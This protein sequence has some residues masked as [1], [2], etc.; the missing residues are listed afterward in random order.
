MFRTG[1]LDALGASVVEKVST[2]RNLKRGYGMHTYDVVIVGA[3][4][5][6]L[7]AAYELRDWD[8][9]VLEKEGRSGG[10]ILTRSRGGVSYD[11]GAV[12]AIDHRI[13]PFEFKTSDLIYEDER[14]GLFMDGRVHYGAGV[15]ECLCCMGIDAQDREAIRKFRVDQERDARLLPEPIYKILNAFFQVIHPGE[16]EEYLPHRRLDALLK[17]VVTHYEG[18]N[19]E[20]IGQFEERLGQRVRLTAEVLSVAEERGRVR[21]K[22][23]H[24]NKRCEVFAKTVILSPPGPVALRVLKSVSG[25]CRSFL[26]SL[27]YGEGA[28]VALG[29]QETEFADFSYIVTPNLPTNTILKQSTRNGSIQIL[30]A[31]YAGNKSVKLKGRTDGWIIQQTLDVL[32]QLQIAAIEKKNIIFSDVCSWPVMGPVI[33]KESYSKWDE[34]V[35]RPSKRVFLCGEYVYGSS[36]NVFPYGMVAALSSG[37]TASRAARQFLKSE[38]TNSLANRANL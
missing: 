30:L 7:M 34:R 26:S 17:H 3:G 9:L 36:Q 8:I 4:L 35:A 5:S 18:G 14:I 27:R 20:F 25:P 23:L 6:G 28:V 33:S 37:K 12:F 21:V 22:Y 13:L 10:R 32:G 15:M 11:L 38:T 19:G 24:H 2:G 31:Y 16:M 29:F 1:V